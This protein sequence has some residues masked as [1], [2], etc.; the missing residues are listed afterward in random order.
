MFL[1]SFFGQVLALGVVPCRIEILRRN[2]MALGD[3]LDLPGSPG[4]VGRLRRLS[5]WITW[6]SL[7][8]A[9]AGPT[10][11]SVRDLLNWNQGRPIAARDFSVASPDRQTA[12]PSPDAIRAGIRHF[13]R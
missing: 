7:A 6:S 5:Y 1:V 12:V 8:G 9:D 11:R 4:D 2:S 3:V 10:S 13:D